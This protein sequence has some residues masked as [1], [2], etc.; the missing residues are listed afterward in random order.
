MADRPLT[1]LF[2]PESAYGPTGNCIGIGNV[3]LQKGHQVVFAAESSWNG[4]LEPLGFVEDLVDL[5]P[6]P[7]APTADEQDAGAF[8]KE[9]IKQTSPEFRKPTVDQLE[10]F[11]APTYQA[12]I[13]GAMYCEPHLIDIIERHQPDVLVE[14]NVVLF[15]AL[16]TSGAPFVRIVSCNPLE[17][18]GP[19]VAPTFSGLPGDDDSEW[20][21]FRAEYE[22]THRSMWTAFNE[23]VVKAGADPLPDLDFM[24]ESTHANLYLFPQ[25]A[26]YVDRR[27]L[28]ATWHRI[29]SSVRSTDD[30]FE[31]PAE[32]ADRPVGS[33]LVY[34]SL[35]SLGSADVDLMKRLVDVLGRTRHR[36]I[37][38]KGPQHAEYRLADNM[39][40]REFLPQ[41]SLMPLVDLVITHGG[42][43]TT[44]EAL[45]F[46]K[47]MVLLP[48]FW[49]QYDNAQ[50]MDELGFGRRLRTY[51]FTDAELIDAVDGLLSD[52]G[53]A[54]RLTRVG[55]SIRA[56]LGKERA[57]DII[58]QVGRT[59][60]AGR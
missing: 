48:L 24:P 22:R 10:T 57:A 1:V 28:G 16:T 35:G 49:D 5:A 17:V 12:L 54:A 8:W 32:L 60:R 15:P 47:P 53:L 29:D 7:E 20:A 3:L 45:H 43:N 36:Y 46:G 40:G 18:K 38:S 39:W 55:E 21:S 58:E 33:R 9:F 11:I 59:H 25:E 30:P 23:F 50:R 44:T 56:R 19:G 6:P 27:P 31:L 42:N 4:K 51:E 2:L 26:D 37:V 34:L 52:Q 13:D 41:T 14:D